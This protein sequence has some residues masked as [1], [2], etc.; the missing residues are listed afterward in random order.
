MLQR[1]YNSATIPSTIRR[2]IP[3]AGTVYYIKIVTPK[4]T[5]YKIGYTCQDI[6]ARINNFKLSPDTDVYLVDSVANT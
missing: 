2:N 6:L 3:N 4:H 5:V 1:Y